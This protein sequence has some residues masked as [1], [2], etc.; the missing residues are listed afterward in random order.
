MLAAR[1]DRR[2]T[3][4]QNVI[5]TRVRT[6]RLGDLELVTIENDALSVSVL[7]GAGGKI[8]SIISR[9]HD[10][11]VLWHHPAIAPAAHPPGTL[12]DDV[13][14]G[15]WDEV[16]PNDAP[17]PGTDTPLLDHGAI[18]TA[19]ATVDVFDDAPTGEALHLTTVDPSRTWRLERTLSLAPIGARLT[20]AYALVNLSTR[21]QALQWKLHP[22]LPVR[23]GMKLHLPGSR[24]AIDPDFA[25]GFTTRPGRW[26]HLADHDGRQIDLRHLPD[27]G[28]GSMRF[29][30]ASQLAA[31]WCGVHWPDPGLSLR[32]D[33]DSALFRA[34][35]VF[36]TWGGWRDLDV[37]ILEP[38]TGAGTSLRALREQGEALILA[39][40]E[41]RATTVM[42]TIDDGQQFLGQG[43]N[44]QLTS[45]GVR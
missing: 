38:A 4:P 35:T 9:A 36:A 8:W 30:H 6:D 14:A 2:R 18:W 22:A 19:P 23:H 13:W 20:T 24:V 10:F 17:D 21:F 37:L 27:P 33:F 41:R 26:P 31:G 42:V 39:P 32:L 40:G 15:G 7:P 34:V 45:S 3:L 12:F 43:T 1:I 29:F 16:L 11:D 28:S 5:A 44:D 25:A